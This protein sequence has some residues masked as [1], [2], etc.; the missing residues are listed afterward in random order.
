MTII[1]VVP[2]RDYGWNLSRVRPFLFNL[3]VVD[4]VAGFYGVVMWMSIKLKFQTYVTFKSHQSLYFW[5]ILVTAWGIELHALGFLLKLFAPSCPRLLS[6]IISNIG[7]ICNVTGFAIVL[8][9][10]PHLVVCNR[11]I[12]RLVLAM[13][14]TDVFIL[15][16]PLTTTKFGLWF[17][18]KTSPTQP[19]WLPV[20][21]VI[22]RIQITRFILQ[23]KH[24]LLHLH[25]PDV[26]VLEVWLRSTDTQCHFTFHCHAGRRSH[27]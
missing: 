1:N 4:L 10:R 21:Q 17:T 26:E 20:F 15:H 6:I 12:L 3:V 5:P 25:L 16:V 18:S 27:I 11:L 9:S 23:E 24:Y 2:F 22:E 14:I 13:I 8:Y 7:W 19:M